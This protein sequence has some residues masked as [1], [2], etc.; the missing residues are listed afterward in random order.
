MYGSSNEQTLK[1]LIQQL[2]DNYKLQDGIT[3]AK[4]I[5]SWEKIAGKYI[6][7]QTDKIYIKNGILYLKIKSPAL[8]HELSFAKSKLMA[9]LNKSIGQDYIKEVVF[10]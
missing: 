2:L 10:I 9:A 7:G 4:L 6:A 1:E 8:K 5:G 3:R